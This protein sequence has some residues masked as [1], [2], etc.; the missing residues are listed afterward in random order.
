MRRHRRLVAARRAVLADEAGLHV[1]GVGDE[2]IAFPATGREASAGVLGV[3]GWVRPPVHPDGHRR[4]IFP[5]ANRPRDRR[6]LDWLRVA[7]DL[8][9][10]R[11]LDEIEGRPSLALALDHRQLRLVVAQRPGA[12]LVI[13]READVVHWIRI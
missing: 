4:P 2:R 12:P 8:Q 11:T 7:P 13:K 1:R 10:E 9:T 3:L 5:G 6:A